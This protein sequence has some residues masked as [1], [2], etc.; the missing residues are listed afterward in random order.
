MF[1]ERE[2]QITQ[3]IQGTLPTY[4]EAEGLSDFNRYVNDFI[5]LD[6]YKDKTVF[7]YNFGSYDIVPLTNESGAGSFSFDV[8]MVFRGEAPETLHNKMLNYAD[9]FYKMFTESGFNFGGCVDGTMEIEC[10]FYNAA[11][12]FPGN[13]VCL[14]TFT[15]T[16]EM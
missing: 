3:F 7:F 11:E 2:E 8:Y 10:Y 15:T 5:D 1:R 6:K 16:S 14:M 4:L 12:G 13:K 9:V